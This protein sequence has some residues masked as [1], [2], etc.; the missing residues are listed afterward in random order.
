MTADRLDSAARERMHELLADL[1]AHGL[2]PTEHAELDR[3]VSAAGRDDESFDS[4]AAAVALAFGSVLGELGREP[5]SPELRSRLLAS[6]RAAVE[7]GAAANP[8]RRRP[9]PAAVWSGWIVAA[10]AATLAVVGWWPRSAASSR[11]ESIAELRQAL[12][13]SEPD[14]VEVAFKPGPD[15][16]GKGV[17][18]DLV[19]SPRAQRGFLRFRGL[20]RNDPTESQYQLWIFD[21]GQDERYPIDG[22]LFDVDAATGEVFVAIAARLKVV[23]PKLFAVTI[24]KSGGVVV[25]ARQRIAALAQM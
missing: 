14:A 2:S 22:G 18:G 4:A 21:A 16:E 10:A 25:S 12:I 24:E 1:A 6:G 20:P 17:S 23:G 11:T 19:W 15:P 7:Q 5:L 13:A 9:S 8:R 3:L